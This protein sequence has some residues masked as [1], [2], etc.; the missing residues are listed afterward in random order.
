MKPVLHFLLTL[1][2]YISLDLLF[3]GILARSFV[4]RQVGFLMAPHPD[5]LAAGLFYLI[6]SAGL[7]YFCIYPALRENNAL[8]ALLNGAF[9]GL[10]TYATYELVNKSLIDKWPWP[11]VWV[12]ILWGVVVGAAVSWISFQVS[13]RL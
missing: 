7:L 12:D 5:W 8:R 6:F 3:L 1:A 9:F 4:E 13:K 10:V 2:T 11:F